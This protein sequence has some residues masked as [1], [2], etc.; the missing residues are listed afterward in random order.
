MSANGTMVDIPASVHGAEHPD[1]VDHRRQ[2]LVDQHDDQ[3]GAGLFSAGR[4]SARDL[5]S[6]VQMK[7]LLSAG[8]RITRSVELRNDK[9]I[10]RRLEA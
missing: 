6:V 8:T 7:Y 9:E 2:R 1:G 5:A 10:V 4:R 3:F